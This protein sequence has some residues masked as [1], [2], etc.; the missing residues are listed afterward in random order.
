MTGMMTRMIIDLRTYPYQT[1]D[2]SF[3]VGTLLNL[4]SKKSL[5]Y[6]AS[7]YLVVNITFPWPDVILA[8]VPE[9]AALSTQANFESN[10][11]N[12]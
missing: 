9:Q 6:E 12:Y 1:Y 10:K 7:V 11:S 3:F 2:Y 5:P 8:R 4:D